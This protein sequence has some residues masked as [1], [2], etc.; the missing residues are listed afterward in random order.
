V[1][2]HVTISE[3]DSSSGGGGLNNQN[4]S[5]PVLINAA[6]L[7]NETT[8]GSAGG[9]YNNGSS[10][11]L[12]NVTVG[13]NKASGGGGGI[14]NTGSS[15]PVL[16]NVTIAGNYN[17]S[18]IG[19]G[20]YN[21]SST[22]VIRNS[23]IWGNIASTGNGISPVGT[24]DISYSIVDNGGFPIAP[25]SPD[26]NITIDP[27]F[28]APEP[29]ASAPITTGNYS[30]QSTSPARN[31]GSNVVYPDTWTLWQSLVG[32]TVGLITSTTAYDTYV[33]DA[34]TKDLAGNSRKNGVID[35]GAYEF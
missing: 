4:N 17:P 32:S 29:A 9:I 16:I 13:G 15:A 8:S 27:L 5:S 31:A 12:I 24:S 1:L 34:L 25:V 2:T 3:N 30:L 23:I 18:G 33:K 6:I 7:G 35:M 22:P 10:P 28:T 26:F 21:N 19:G 14:Y 11:V 20:I